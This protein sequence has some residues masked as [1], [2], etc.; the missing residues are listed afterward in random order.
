MSSQPG[1]DSDSMGVPRGESGSGGASTPTS[2]SAPSR[3][4]YAVCMLPCPHLDLFS[5]EARDHSGSDYGRSNEDGRAEQHDPPSRYY[6]HDQTQG[7]A[8]VHHPPRGSAPYDSIGYSRASMAVYDPPRPPGPIAVGGHLHSRQ[9]NLDPQPA[10]PVMTSYYNPAT[11]QAQQSSQPANYPFSYAHYPSHQPAFDHAPAGYHPM[12]QTSADVG[13]VQS[14][15]AQLHHQIGDGPA[16]P[17]VH[18]TAQ[19]QE[20]RADRN[21]YYQSP[22]VSAHMGNDNRQGS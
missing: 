13:G 20:P 5:T 10:S 6:G 17:S 19:R 7:Q 21:V 12:M 18:P 11:L 3:E 1:F 15:E 14:M 2:A 4:W 16:T 9:P 8:Y 22:P